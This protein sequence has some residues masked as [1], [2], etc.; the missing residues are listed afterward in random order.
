MRAPRT[1]AEI[2][3]IVGCTRRILKDRQARDRTVAEIMRLCAT[4][5]DRL[6]DIICELLDIS[7]DELVVFSRE[8][9]AER[10][11]LARLDDEGGRP[12]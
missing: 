9:A 1:D 12:C 4:V 5:P 11:A 6:I 7:V 10:L 2:E 3:V 8:R